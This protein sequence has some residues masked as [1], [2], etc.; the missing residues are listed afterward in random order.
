MNLIISKKNKVDKSLNLLV[1]FM[2]H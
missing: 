2:A 1:E